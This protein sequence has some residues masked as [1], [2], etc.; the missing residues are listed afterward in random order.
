MCVLVLC[1]V[2]V[3]PLNNIKAQS[4]NEVINKIQYFYDHISSL[5]AVFVQETLF[6]DGRREIRK[7]KVWI[8]KPGKMRWEYSEP[9]RFLIISNGEKLFVY[10]PEEKQVFIYPSGKAISSHLALGFMSGR[11]DIKKDLKLESFKILKKN[12]WELSFISAFK[13]PQVKKIILIVNLNTGEVKQFYVINQLG[14]KI[15]ITFNKIEYNSNI[16]DKI[17]NL[18]LSKDVEVIQ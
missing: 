17:F 9:E 7:G 5:K 1:W 15:K 13:D 8:K 6:P 4:I 3:N 2:F 14:E 10:Y 16:K 18:K 12:L 11:G